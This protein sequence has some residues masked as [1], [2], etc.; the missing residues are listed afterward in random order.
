MIQPVNVVAR[1]IDNPRQVLPGLGFRH[2]RALLPNRRLVRSTESA[3]R[4]C[5]A[6]AVARHYLGYA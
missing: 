3:N 1:P 6:C 5:T 4:F 2:Q